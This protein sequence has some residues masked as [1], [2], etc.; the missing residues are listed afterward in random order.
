MRLTV[1]AGVDLVDPLACCWG[2]QLAEIC[3]RA[4]VRCARADFTGEQRDLVD[5]RKEVL[6]NCVC[7]RLDCV[8]T[9]VGDHCTRTD[10]RTVYRA[11]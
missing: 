1:A 8:R 3:G 6:R 4:D 9:V 5:R 11:H 2:I 10:S 7:G